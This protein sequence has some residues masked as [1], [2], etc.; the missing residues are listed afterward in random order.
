MNNQL[1]LECK[2]HHWQVST[3]GRSQTC[4]NCGHLEE[5]LWEKEDKRYTGRLFQKNV[6]GER[7]LPKKQETKE[8]RYTGVKRYCDF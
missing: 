5:G 3:D 4:I 2:V 1:K 6:T 7:L 8:Y